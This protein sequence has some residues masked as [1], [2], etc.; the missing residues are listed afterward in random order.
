MV[1]FDAQEL[2]LVKMALA[3]V[4]SAREIYVQ[5]FGRKS[6]RRIVLA[7]TYDLIGGKARFLGKLTHR[8]LVRILAVFKLAGR[9]F[10][11][12]LLERVAELPYAIAIVLVVDR[13]YSRAAR[14]LNYLAL[15]D[16]SVAQLGV[17]KTNIYND[18]AILFS[19]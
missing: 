6:G 12:L 16:A 1:L 19:I 11:Q 7:E 8:A 17:V 15:Y 9:R 14:M 18:A 2:S 4:K 13:Q 3:A 10:K 5:R